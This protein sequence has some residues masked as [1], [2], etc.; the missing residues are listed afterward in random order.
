[1]FQLISPI[2]HYPLPITH[3]PLP[4]THY[5]LT[6]NLSSLASLYKFR[7]TYL[8]QT[9]SLPY[10]LEIHLEEPTSD[11]AMSCVYHALADDL[12]EAEIRYRTLIQI[13][14]SHL[15][16][17]N[18]THLRFIITPADPFAV[19][20][21]SFWILPLFRGEIQKVGDHFLFQP[22]QFAPEFTIEFTAEKNHPLTHEKSARLSAHSPQCSSRWINM[23]MQQCSPSTA[24]EGKDYLYI[25]HK[26]QRLEYSTTSIPALPVVHS[27]ADWKLALESPIGPKLQKIYQEISLKFS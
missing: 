27:D 9:M 2:T 15:T 12:T 23:A 11:P 21:V 19:E 17:L 16:G 25:H 10:I 8:Q 26:N 14:I 1:M 13:L 7:K 24:I 3:Y 4:I 22:Q 20:A 18:Q 6:F 5:P